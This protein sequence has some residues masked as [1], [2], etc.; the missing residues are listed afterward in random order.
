MKTIRSKVTYLQMFE[1]PKRPALVPIEGA[2]VIQARKPTIAFCR[3]LNDAVG[4]PWN[5]VD[6]KRLSD[7]ELG[8]IVHDPN[9]ETHVL[10]ADGTP[11][12]FAELDRRT[13]GQ[14]EL[15]YFGLMPEFLGQGL[16][17]YFLSWVVDRS[18]SY[19]PQRLWVHTCD[20]DHE[21]ALSVYQKGGFEIYDEEVIDQAV[22]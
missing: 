18:W 4:G 1:P 13:A 19:H 2:C 6:R 21:A 16:G 9:V 15:A 11:A 12:G 17:K 8:V 10:Y 7:Q 22:L 3:F 14:I 20:L 5:W